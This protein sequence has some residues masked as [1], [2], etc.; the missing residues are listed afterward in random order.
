MTE[1]EALRAEVK[2][3]A[4]AFDAQRRALEHAWTI[5]KRLQAELAAVKRLPTPLPERTDGDR[6]L[7][8]HEAGS[9][10][11]VGTTRIPW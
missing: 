2:A 4:R 8:M 6:T 10:K 3:L 11:Q 5:A 1:V 9:E 7:A